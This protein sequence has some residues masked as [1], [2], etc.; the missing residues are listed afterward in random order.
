MLDITVNQVKQTCTFCELSWPVIRGRY[1]N[2]R[3][4]KQ[5]LSS[6]TLCD[7]QNDQALHLL[8]LFSLLRREIE[9][10]GK[11][12]NMVGWRD[13]ETDRGEAGWTGPD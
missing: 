8:Q 3:L 9:G 11:E 2:A 10:R 6:A 1:I 13:G 5:G 4:E 12:G 7:C